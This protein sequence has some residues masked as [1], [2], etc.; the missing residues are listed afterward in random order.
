MVGG[1]NSIYEGWLKSTLGDFTWKEV[2][3]TIRTVKNW[4]MLPERLHTL[5]LW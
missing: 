2:V 1:G 3:F 4:N 5:H